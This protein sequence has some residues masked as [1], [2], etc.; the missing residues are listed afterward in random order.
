MDKGT[1]SGA[2]VRL[3]AAVRDDVPSLT[4]IRSTPEVYRRWGGGDDLAGVVSA[5]LAD[6]GKQ[7]LAIL[8]EDQVVGAIQWSEEGDPDY[9]HASIDI[10][11]DPAFHSR[12]LGGDA[13]RTLAQHLIDDMGHHRLVTDPAAD[14]HAAIR[15]YAKVGF[16]QVGVMRRYERGPDGTW[17]DGMLMDLLAHEL[18]RG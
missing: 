13:V 3:R 16:Q 18:V 9:R 10:Y 2:G 4:R 11:L 15:C 8:F 14:N 12:G 5:D 17:H 6:P 1:L 7:L